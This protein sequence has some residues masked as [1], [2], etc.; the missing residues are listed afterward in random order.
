MNNENTDIE[1]EKKVLGI[2]I[3]EPIQLTNQYSKLSINLFSTTEHQI[4]FQEISQIWQEKQALDLV[5]LQ[6][7]FT[8]K[9]FPQN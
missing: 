2:L 5:I 7:E 6:R 8:K 1:L 3:M 4:I 9:I